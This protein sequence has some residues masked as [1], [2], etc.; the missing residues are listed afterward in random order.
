M[1]LAGHPAGYAQNLSTD[2]S[3]IFSQANALYEKKDYAA[4]QVLYQQLVDGGH[5]SK[6]LF[7]N[8]GNTYYKLK[9][10]GH[11]VYNYER[12]LRLDPHDEDVLFNLE[13]TR[14]YLKDKLVTP[15]DF[16]L[17]DISKKIMHLFA[18]ETWAVI[19]LTVWFLFAAMQLLRRIMN[20]RGKIP[21]MANFTVGFLLIIC[22]LNFAAN[23]HTHIKVKEAVVLAQAS[24]VWS[25]PDH[26]S[27]ILFVLHEGTKVQIRSERGDWIEIRLTDG[28]V[29]WLRKDDAGA[30]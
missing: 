29:G 15:P 23:I 18:M 25:E 6:P 24:D 5:S 2:P 3:D 4:A 13:L 22:V 8:L 27:S 12:A 10:Y 9:K 30:L 19:S 26:S 11:A 7:Y 21:K 16:I 28:K 14:L 1:L 17:Y 20:L